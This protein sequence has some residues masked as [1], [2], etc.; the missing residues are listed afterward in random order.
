MKKPTISST[1]FD[2]SRNAIGDWIAAT[3]CGASVCGMREIDMHHPSAAA[4]IT[5]TATMPVVSAVL[6]RIAG[7]SR[8]FRV[9]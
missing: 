5:S 8:T 3:S 9:R 2:T 1:R 4:A 7:M 6:T